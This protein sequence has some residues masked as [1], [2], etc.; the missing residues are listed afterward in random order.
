MT[1]PDIT[2]CSSNL[3]CTTSWQVVGSLSSNHLALII[4]T[5]TRLKH[6]GHR[7]T[8]TNYNTADR[9]AFNGESEQH[10]GTWNDMLVPNNTPGPNIQVFYQEFTTI[11]QNIGKRHIPRDN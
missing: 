9:T 8:Y 10:F 6:E 5:Q 2:E 1:S 7:S 11:I 3:S 4:P